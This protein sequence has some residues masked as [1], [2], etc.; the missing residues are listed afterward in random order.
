LA[1]IRSVSRTSCDA[2]ISPGS[3]CWVTIVKLLLKRSNVTIANTEENTVTSAM[4]IKPAKTLEEIPILKF[5]VINPL[6]DK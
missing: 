6:I 3:F 1:I 4:K 5:E 2:A